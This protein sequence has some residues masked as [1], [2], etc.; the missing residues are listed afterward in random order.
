[1]FWAPASSTS[2]AFY[3]V[4]VLFSFFY[5]GHCILPRWCLL[6]AIPRNGPFFSQLN[7]F[8]IIMTYDWYCCWK[9][10]SIPIFAVK[11]RRN[12]LNTFVKF[13]R[14]IHGSAYVLFRHF[15][16]HF[17]V[18]KNEYSFRQKYIAAHFQYQEIQKDWNQSFWHFWW[19]WCKIKFCHINLTSDIISGNHITF[20]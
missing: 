5:P 17:Y 4:N 13:M 20:I 9:I 2:F 15:L 1:M 6:T 18:D 12:Q 7:W 11:F 19:Y 8:R 10:S 16:S 14:I 3:S